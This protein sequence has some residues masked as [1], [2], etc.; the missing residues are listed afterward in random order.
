[1][2]LGDY[3]KSALTGRDLPADLELDLRGGPI[4]RQ[5]NPAA[6]DG[7]HRSWELPESDLRNAFRASPAAEP[8]LLAPPGF[9]ASEG[10]PQAS[11]D[12]DAI[13][14]PLDDGYLVAVQQPGRP[15]RGATAAASTL[16]TYTDFVLVVDARLEEPG[17]AGYAIH[18]RGSDDER[19]TLVVDAERRSASF[20][21]RSHD[22][23][24][25][26]WDWSPQPSLR[27]A[28]QENRFT[29]R[30]VGQRW[31]AWVNGAQM[32]DLEAPG[33]AS[34]SI[35]LGVVTWDQPAQAVFRNFRLSAPD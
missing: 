16:H 23:T 33:R 28:D 22:V 35:W 20:Y 13:V 30:A 10:W 25:V 31:T 5:Y 32:F 17:S 4:L 1:L 11:D 7:L 18:L 3:L 12:P 9:P 14:G 21:H 24:S 2:L 27:A 19:L 26:V 15:E 34:G 29:I 6:A 8:P